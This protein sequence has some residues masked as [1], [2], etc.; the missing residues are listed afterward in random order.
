[1]G[2]LLSTLITLQEYA[3]E[4]YLA[5]Y[6][7]VG[8]QPSREYEDPELTRLA[9]QLSPFAFELV[10]REHSSVT[11]P[12]A[13][14]VVDI[15]ADTAHVESPI[16]GRVHLVNMCTC[17]CDFM[18]TCLLSC[19]HVMYMR[20]TSNYKTVV[21]PLRFFATRW[22]V[23]SPENNIDTGEVILGGLKQGFCD[24]RTNEK[25]LSGANIYIEA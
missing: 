19:C 8:S 6:H 3:E 12:N 1:M 14:Y 4:Q 25:A 20:S 13:D 23:Q 24:A 7:R 17:D 15:Q 10:S 11:G 22:I 16:S 9:F 5:E 18:T 2:H 21:P